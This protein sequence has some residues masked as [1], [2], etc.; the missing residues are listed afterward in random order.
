MRTLAAVSLAALGALILASPAVAGPVI[1]SA[2]GSNA[3]GIQATVDRFRADLGGALN[4]NNGVAAPNGRREINWDGVADGSSE[5]F[6]GN[7]F[8]G[9]TSRGVVLSTPGTNLQVSLTAPVEFDDVNPT[10]STA[11]GVFSTPKLF[12]PR[13]STVTDVNFLGGT[14]QAGSDYSAV[15]T[16]VTFAATRRARQSRSRSAPTQSPRRARTSPCRSP[17]RSAARSPARGRPR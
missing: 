5:P 11:F 3:A 10:Y 15:N 7:F 12:T 16:V 6:P 13:G 1:R 2:S 4:P 9:A 14:G 17:T 8:N